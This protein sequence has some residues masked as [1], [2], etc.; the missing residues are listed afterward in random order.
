MSRLENLIK[1]IWKENPVLVS[2]LGLCSVMAVTTTVQNA[3]GLGLGFTFVLILSNVIISLIRKIVPNE[4][5]IPVYIVVVA[6]LVTLVEMIMEAFF[7]GLYDSLGIW[8]SLIVVN[9]IILGRAEAFASQNGVLDSFLDA[10]GMAIGYTLV[11]LLI[12]LIREFFGT[13]SITIWENIKL[14]ITNP[15]VKKIFN[16]FFI[17]P[18]AAFIILGFIIGIATYFKNRH[19]DKKVEVK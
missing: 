8:I 4:I 6:T 10:V 1:G 13:G 18:P 19:N 16:D 17:N 2:L 7:P 9:C 12:A 5:R 15:N 11:I 14:T 3:I